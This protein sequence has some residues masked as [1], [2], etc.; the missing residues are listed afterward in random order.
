MKRTIGLLLAVALATGAGLTYAGKG[1]GG[2][3]R[4]GGGGH[5]F[6][7]GGAR[8]G[9]GGFSHFTTGPTRFTTGPM[10][11]TTGPRPSH[12]IAGIRP[13]PVVVARPGFPRNRVIVGGAVVVAAP[14]WY[15]PY[16]PYPY[17]YVSPAYGGSAYA[18]VPT[19]SDAPANYDTSGY[20]ERNDYWYYCPDSQTYYPYVATCA[21]PWVPVLPEPSSGAPN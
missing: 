10:R 18:E 5:A 8:P 2:G 14:F 3:G 13:G 17:A 15:P 7:G 6:A 21:S 1:G 20:S 4:A 12:P 19:Y 16:Y 11:F 9:N